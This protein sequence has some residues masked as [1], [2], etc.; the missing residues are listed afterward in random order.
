M[1][2]ADLVTATILLILAAIV[3]WDSYE[4]GIAWGVGGPGS[5]F[6]PFWMG[7]IMIGCCLGI[8]AQAVR[9]HDGKPFIARASI[10]SGAR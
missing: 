2:K 9:R 8:I 1:R 7:L 10:G 6:F 4:L 5:G 3:V